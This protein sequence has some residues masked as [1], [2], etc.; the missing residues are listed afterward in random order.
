MEK[1]LLIQILANQCVLYHE[2]GKLMD[3]AE[4]RLRSRSEK[5]IFTDLQKDAEK[6]RKIIEAELKR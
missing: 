2:I 5:F 4:N 6:F 1:E 3:K